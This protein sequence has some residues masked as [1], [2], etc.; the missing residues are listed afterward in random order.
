MQITDVHISLRD[1]DKLKGFVKIV[2]DDEFI[3]KDIKIISGEERYFISM[4][5]HRVRGDPR[6]LVRSCP[7]SRGHEAGGP[8]GDR[9][10]LGHH[11]S[12][13]DRRRH[14]GRGL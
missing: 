8:P 14:H 1:E 2:L 6:P 3:V 13:Q 11:A 7:S 9:R 12:C 4:P 10:Q 5:S